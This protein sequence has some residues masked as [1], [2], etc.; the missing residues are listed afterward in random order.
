IILS[1]CS[2]DDTGKITYEPGLFVSYANVLMRND[3]RPNTPAG[4]ST[5]SFVTMNR[6]RVDYTG[7]LPSGPV[8]IRPIDVGG[9]TVGIAPDGTGTMQVLV[10]DYARHDYILSHYPTVGTTDTLTLRATITM[11]GEDA[12]RAEVSTTAEVTLVIA[13]YDRC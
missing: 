10:M 11:W 8:S 2:T 7:S 13:N 1:E 5:N 9:L 3:S 4:Q 12:F 6:Y